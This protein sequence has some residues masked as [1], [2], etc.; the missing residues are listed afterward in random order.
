MSSEDSLLDEYGSARSDGIV[1]LLPTAG[2]HQ[3]RDLYLRQ[4]N[5]PAAFVRDQA[6]CQ[7]D[8]RQ[9]RMELRPDLPRQLPAH[10]ASVQPWPKR[11]EWN[12]RATTCHPSLTVR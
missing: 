12:L 10:P 3:P 7:L 1:P 11:R 6:P 8:R 5:N 2:N 4:R 9:P